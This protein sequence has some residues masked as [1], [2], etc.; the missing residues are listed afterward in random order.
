[1]FY[2]YILQSLENGN[3]YIGYSHDLEKRIK[4]HDNGLNSSTKKGLPWNLIY[5]EA[6]LMESDAKRREAYLKTSQGKR[7]IKIRL[8]DFFNN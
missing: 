1:M 3:L 5:Y 4:E 8:K 7:L 6:C 2:T